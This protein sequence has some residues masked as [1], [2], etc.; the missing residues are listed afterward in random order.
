MCWKRG[1]SSLGQVFKDNFNTAAEIIVG[2]AC[3]MKEFTILMDPSGGRH[4]GGAPRQQTPPSRRGVERVPVDR[5][6]C[7]GQVQSPH[8][9]KACGNF[10]GVFECHLVTGEGE[11]RNER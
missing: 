3:E 10:I 7:W 11:K 8:Q 1:L 6:L 9:P 4:M 5:C 2:E